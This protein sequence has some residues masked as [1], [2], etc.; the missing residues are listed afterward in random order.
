MQIPGIPPIEEFHHHDGGV[1]YGLPWSVDP[2]GADF[3]LTL[4]DGDPDE[5]QGEWL[6]H[7][8]SYEMALRVLPE[9]ESLKHQALQFLGKIVDFGKLALDGEPYVSHVTCDARAERVTVELAWTDELYVRLGVTFFWRDRNL[10][11]MPHWCWP[12][13]M[14][15]RNA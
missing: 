9:L 11:Q 6:P 2:K 12:V 7:R 4:P 5:E 8:G 10:G 1:A 13:E 14:S 3:T 15:F